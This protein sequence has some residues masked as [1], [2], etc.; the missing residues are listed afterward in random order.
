VT[1]LAHSGVHTPYANLAALPQS[2]RAKMRLTHYP[3]EFEVDKSAIEVLRQGRRYE[4]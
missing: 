2:L 1:T 4:L 3:D